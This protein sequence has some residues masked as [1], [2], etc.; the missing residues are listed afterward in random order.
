MQCLNKLTAFPMGVDP[1]E[2]EPVVAQALGD[3]VIWDLLKIV[4]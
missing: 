2:I 4:I 1:E 3:K